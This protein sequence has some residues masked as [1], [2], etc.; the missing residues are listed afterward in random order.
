[1]ASCLCSDA[2]AWVELG[3]AIEEPANTIKSVV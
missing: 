2:V 1:L 3:A